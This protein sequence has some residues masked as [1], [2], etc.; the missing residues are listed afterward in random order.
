MELL[1]IINMNSIS[2]NHY[3]NSNNVAV[4]AHLLCTYS[5]TINQSPH[6]LASDSQ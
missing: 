4:C 5:K 6:Q 2:S 1:N 3:Q